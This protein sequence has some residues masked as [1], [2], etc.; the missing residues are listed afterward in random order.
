MTSTSPAS[1]ISWSERYTLASPALVPLLRSASWSSW[2][3]L[4]LLAWSSALCPACRCRVVRVRT[5]MPDTGSP[6]CLSASLV[7]GTG[8]CALPDQAA[9]DIDDERDG[10]DVRAD[11]DRGPDRDENAADH[12]D[13]R[14]HDRQNRH[15]QRRGADLGR[16]RRGDTEQREHEQRADDLD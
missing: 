16:G 8:G 10:G 1:A 5:S 11:R 7:S 12:R 2:A 3:V 6:F 15:P 4:K 9:R 14:E 13:Q